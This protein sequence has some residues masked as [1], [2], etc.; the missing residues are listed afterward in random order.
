M[1]VGGGAVGR[2]KATALLEG[3]ARVRVVCLEASPTDLHSSELEWRTE[4]YRADHLAGA[5]LV[6][7]AA[8]AA[9]NRCVSADAHQRGLWVNVADDPHGSD[10]FMPAV[11]RRGAFTVA[12]GTGG[13]APALA[14]EVRNL[15]DTQFD[16]AFGQWVSLLAELRPLVLAQVTECEVRRALFERWCRGEWLERLRR[17]GAGEVRKALLAEVRALAPGFAPRL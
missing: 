6:F 7:A 10:F 9:V 3:G 16:D 17:E 8:T 2:R 4:P 12:V 15:L 11:L 14:Q 5:A 13:A 1:V